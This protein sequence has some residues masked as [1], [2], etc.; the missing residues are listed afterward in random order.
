MKKNIIFKGT[1][2]LSFLI[3][4]LVVAGCSAK[5][6]NISGQAAGGDYKDI[7]EVHVKVVGANYVFEPST[8]KK[9]A[10]VKLIFDM[11]TVDGCA[12]S[13][14]IPA[15]NI[16]KALSEGNN[17]I[18]FSPSKAGLYRIACSMNMYTGEFT[19]E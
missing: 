10:V 13:V 12:R 18:T 2:V 5:G 19:V 11:N 4:A 8:L 1:F 7:Q 6:D 14:V 16:Q 15:F 9:D 17:V 3:L